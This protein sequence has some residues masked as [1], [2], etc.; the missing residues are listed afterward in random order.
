MFGICPEKTRNLKVK[1]RRDQLS[2]VRE[3]WGLVRSLAEKLLEIGH[4]TV[5]YYVSPLLL[6]LYVIIRVILR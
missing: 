3:V 6:Y 4:Y 2:L 1:T 5:L